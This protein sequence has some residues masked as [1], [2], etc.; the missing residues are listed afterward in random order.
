MKTYVFNGGRP[1]NSA[2]ALREQLPAKRL[3]PISAPGQRVINWGCTEVEDCG[4]S[5]AGAEVFNHPSFVKQAANKLTAFDQMNAHGVKVVPF[6]T[7]I[8]TAKSWLTDA[9]V[10]VRH[11]LRGH[12][13]DGIQIVN[14]GE[15]DLPQAPLYTRY[16][17]K[18]YEYR[19]HVMFGLIVDVTRKIRDP[20]KEPTNWK[21]R[22]H[23][24][25]FIFARANL[26]HREAIEP[27]AIEAIQALGL[28]FGAVDII[29]DEQSHQPLVLE[30]NTAPGLE[31]Q[32]L[33]RYVSGF[34]SRLS[35]A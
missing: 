35:Q 1:S 27:V 28:D 9:D 29:I 18:K 7:S 23:A 31:G 14:K 16:C 34:Q 12:S 33:E 3:K 4:N 20:E 24:N 32:T 6:T 26:K 22:S 30:V 17:P 2:K 25:G 13:G 5:F 21:V 10:V 15:Q 19:V 8:D 11:K